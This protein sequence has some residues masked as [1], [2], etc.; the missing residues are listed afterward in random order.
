MIDSAGCMSRFPMPLRLGLLLTL[1]PMQ[2]G[3][4]GQASSV[5]MCQQ[6]V[7]VGGGGVVWYWCATPALRGESV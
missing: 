7:P 4:V 1:W 5:G 2:I 6:P 3:E